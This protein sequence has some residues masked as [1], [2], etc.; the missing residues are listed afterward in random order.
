[1]P[2][3]LAGSWA[4]HHYQVNIR[5]LMSYRFED[6]RFFIGVEALGQAMFG[7][8]TGTIWLDN[9]QCTGSEIALTNC[10]ASSTGVNTCTHAQDAGVRCPGGKATIL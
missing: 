7:Q 1:M 9:I 5:M 10:T 2:V 3:L 8:G 4:W 6:Q